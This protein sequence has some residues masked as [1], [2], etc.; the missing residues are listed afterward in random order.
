M[1]EVKFSPDL[2]FNFGTLT[3]RSELGVQVVKDIG[4]YFK[5]RADIEM[6]Y[7]K[8][9]NQHYKTLP[10]TGM[11]TKDPPVSKESK[12]IKEAL[13][14]VS[15]KGLQVSD[16]HLE[17][18][19]KIINDVC[20]TIDNW[21][22][23]KDNDRKKI[24][25][26]AQK[27][28]KN[29]K[30]LKETAVKNKAN[31]ERMMKDSDAAKDALIKAEKDEINQPENKRLA[32]VTK[33]ASENYN[34]ASTKAKQAEGVYK[35]SVEKFNEELAAFKAEKMPPI[36]EQLNQWEQDRWNTLLSVVKSYATIEQ[37]LPPS[38][39]KQSSE[40]QS[41]IDAANVDAD[42]RELVSGSKNDKEKEEEDL[43]FVQFK[44]KHEDSEPAKPAEPSKPAEST[45]SAEPTK[46]EPT[47]AAEP[48][49]KE[50]ESKEESTFS[51]QTAEEK[52][53]KAKAE[54][55]KPKAPAVSAEQQADQKKKAEAAKAALFGSAGDEDNMFG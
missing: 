22:K 5:K 39:E 33:K 19:N 18:A 34:G 17:V 9:L 54:P 47:K 4:E 41:V 31:Y 40:L 26:D 14:G 16:Q 50:M 7:A 8:K 27:L 45:K 3:T 20:K 51:T 35:T 1:S 12:T 46:S 37:L 2:L 42:L 49:K 52:I 43:E 48:T 24:I 29:Y 38:F 32:Q 15:E 11:F 44:S 25:G 55:V 21:V 53:E 6:E 36:L 13:L 30:D 28:I 23:T 10:G